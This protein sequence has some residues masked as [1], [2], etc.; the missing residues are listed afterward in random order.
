MIRPSSLGQWAQ[1]HRKAFHALRNP[2]APN[3]ATHIQ[4]WIGTMVHAEISGQDP[5]PRPD[6]MAFDD[7]TPNLPVARKQIKIMAREIRDALAIQGW[8]VSEAEY[9]V[10]ANLELEMPHGGMFE[11]RGTADLI[12]WEGLLLE[13]KFI[14]ADLKTGQGIPPG[15]WYQ[16]GAY[17]HG[18]R[19][20]ARDYKSLAVI[21][22]PRTSLDQAQHVTIQIRDPEP[23]REMALAL[24]ESAVETVVHR[25]KE[26]AN[27]G[28]HCHNCRASADCPVRME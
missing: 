28:Y 27:P 18:L 12:L 26:L 9:P 11:Y 24:I 15:V 22:C 5:G 1:C 10:R 4:T 2:E 20:H 6:Y 23:V 21:H 16:L 13:A 3:P 19:D 14:L 17:Y 25:R 7:I 8:E